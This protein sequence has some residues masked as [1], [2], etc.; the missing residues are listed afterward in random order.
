MIIR[1]RPFE[2]SSGSFK[3]RYGFRPKEVFCL[4]IEGMSISASL[5]TLK[6]NCRNV[7]VTVGL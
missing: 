7:P 2:A 5:S 4:S 6:K 1:F 3:P